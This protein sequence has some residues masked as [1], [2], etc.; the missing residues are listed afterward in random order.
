[1]KPRRHKS[2]EEASASTSKVCSYFKKIVP[3]D[4]NLTSA[5]AEGGFTYHSVKHEFSST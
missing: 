5:A 3:E 4:D 1:M 2:A